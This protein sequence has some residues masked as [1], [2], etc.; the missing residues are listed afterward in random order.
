[1]LKMSTK[2]NKLCDIYRELKKID[3]EH[4]YEKLI[5]LQKIYRLSLKHQRFCEYSCNGKGYIK[6]KLIRNDDEDFIKIV[7][8]EETDLFDIEID[9]LQGKINKLLSN[10]LNEFAEYQHDP[11]GL[12]V[13][14]YINYS[15][16]D[17]EILFN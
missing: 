7:D 11:R 8:G 9:K 12:T 2:V 16:I 13:K 14:I 3:D 1:V 6:D 10:N 17:L 5:I 15:L 4:F